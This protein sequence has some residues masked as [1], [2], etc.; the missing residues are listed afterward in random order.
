MLSGVVRIPARPDP[1]ALE[2]EIDCLLSLY[3]SFLPCKLGAKGATLPPLD[4]WVT[5]RT[6]PRDVTG[7][8]MYAWSCAP[9]RPC[10]GLGF[11]Q[12]KNI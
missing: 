2:P 1:Q 11:K 7:T 10:S 3:F 8:V 9:W 6:G 5:R 12:L 4:T